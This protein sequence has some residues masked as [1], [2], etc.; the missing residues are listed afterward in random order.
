VWKGGKGGGLVSGREKSIREDGRKG[1]F[2]R[3]GEKKIV[4]LHYTHTKE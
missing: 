1:F 3:R 2:S 4:L